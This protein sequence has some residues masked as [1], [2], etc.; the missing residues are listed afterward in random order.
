MGRLISDVLIK[1]GLV[2]HL[3]HLNLMEDVTVDIWNPLNGRNLKIMGLI[4][5]VLIKPTRNTSWEELK[6]KIEQV[7]DMY[8]F[9]KI[10]PPEVIKFYLRDLE[11]QDYD[12]SSFNMDWLLDHHPNFMKRKREA[13]QKTIVQKKK[14]LNLGESSATKKKPMSLTSSLAPSGKISIS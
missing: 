11:A 13:S 9:T 1:N 4:E 10:D 7:D 14:I 12:M 6:D 5:K 8:I 2:D 3:I